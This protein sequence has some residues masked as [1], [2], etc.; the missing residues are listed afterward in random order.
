MRFILSRLVDLAWYWFIGYRYGDADGVSK[1]RYL[2][3][4]YLSKTDR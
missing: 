1:L 2:L 4:Y 3:G